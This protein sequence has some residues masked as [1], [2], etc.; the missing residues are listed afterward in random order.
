MLSATLTV[1]PAADATRLTLAVENDGDEPVTL[2]FRD[3]Q[4]AEFVAYD[5]DGTEVWRWS[6]GRMFAQVLTSETLAPGETAEYDATWQSAPDGTYR[7]E[8]W[9]VAENV[10]AS[11]E[12][13]VER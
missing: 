11:A 9:L 2:D 10:D 8:A 4:Q 12:M 13:T 7:I 3:S 6:D 1:S 5:E